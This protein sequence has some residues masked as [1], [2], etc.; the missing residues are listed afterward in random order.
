MLYGLSNEHLLDITRTVAANSRVHQA[1]LFGSRAKG[2]QRPG[3]DIDIALKGNDLTFDDLVSL[4]VALDE[5]WLPFRFD[6]VLYDRIS[7]PAL[8]SHI[9]R[10]G[11]VIVPA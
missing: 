5:L 11:K 10:V 7:E 6:L 3:S 1:V 9:D 2:T 4:G 8:L